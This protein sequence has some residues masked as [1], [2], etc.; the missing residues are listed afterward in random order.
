MKPF[1][2]EVY[3]IKKYVKLANGKI[4]RAYYDKECEEPRRIED[5]EDGESFDMF[6]SEYLGT[7]H[8]YCSSKIVAT[9]DKRKDLNLENSKYKR[10]GLENV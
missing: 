6:Y 4:L 5:S 9:S 2:E 7:M 3:G 10:G 8:L 1:L